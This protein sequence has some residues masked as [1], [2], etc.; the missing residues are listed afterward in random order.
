[1]WAAIPHALVVDDDAGVREVMRM[2]L[3]ADGTWR[4]T[5]VAAAN[6]ALALIL[7]DPPHLAVI[8]AVLPR[9]SG[10]AL[11][12]TVIDF[13][14]PVQIIS[15]EPGIQRLLTESGCPFLLKPFHIS[16]LL[17]QTRLLL[18]ERARRRMEIRVSLD[19]VIHERRELAHIR[20]ETHRLVEASRRLRAER[21]AKDSQNSTK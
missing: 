4:V 6:E 14:I 3:E 7:R 8:D 13:E 12:R 15:G 1:M 10:L 2:G 19:S 18:D 16:E 20:E 21:L 9:V 5:G 17:V 11:A